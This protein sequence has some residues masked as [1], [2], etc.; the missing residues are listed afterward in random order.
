MRVEWAP[1]GTWV[2]GGTESNI[3]GGWSSIQQFMDGGSV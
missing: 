1:S 2:G 3:E